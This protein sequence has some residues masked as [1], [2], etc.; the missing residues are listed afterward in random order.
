MKRPLWLSQ[1]NT[2]ET[3]ADNFILDVIEM[4][5]IDGNTDELFKKQYK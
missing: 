2:E 4:H 5:K 1:P 3:I